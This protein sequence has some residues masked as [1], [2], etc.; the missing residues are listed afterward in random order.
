MTPAQEHD[1]SSFGDDRDSGVLV[2]RDSPAG[3]TGV[4]C[5]VTCGREYFF[6]MID[7]VRTKLAR[8]AND[9]LL[10]SCFPE[11]RLDAIRARIAASN[12]E[13]S[14]WGRWQ[15]PFLFLRNSSDAAVR[16]FD[17]DLRLVRSRSGTNDK[18]I[19][20][21]LTSESEDIQPW[22]GGVFELCVKAT[23]LRN[24][25]A[26]NTWLDWA[27]PNGRRPDLMIDLGARNICIDVHESRREPGQ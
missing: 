18:K 23:A 22:A 2:T 1:S 8:L 9:S 24:S 21:F 14:E 4:H 10:K 17:D 11:A 12:S 16:A 20:D 13:G 5:D 19:L 15:P 7:D 26:L 6:E 3:N 25:E 27:L